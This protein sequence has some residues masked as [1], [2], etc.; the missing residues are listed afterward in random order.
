MTQQSVPGLSI[1]ITNHERLVFAK[2]Y[3][4]DA[5]AAGDSFAW[6]LK[7]VIDGFGGSVTWPG[8]DLF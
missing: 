7:S 6:G 3:G 5:R 2:G 4:F 1:A 8:Y